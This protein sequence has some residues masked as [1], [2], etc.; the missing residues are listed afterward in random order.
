MAE[1]K[2]QDVTARLP[3]KSLLLEVGLMV[4]GTIVGLAK[5]MWKR[6]YGS[7]IAQNRPVY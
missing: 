4:Q 2:K 6:S 5:D 1:T 3:T 7:F